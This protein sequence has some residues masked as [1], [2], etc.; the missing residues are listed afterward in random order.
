LK[1][2]ELA[3]RSGVSI[4]SIK[5]YIREGL[6]RSGDASAPNQARYSEQHLGDLSLIRALRDHA[7]LSIAAIRRVLVAVASVEG[8]PDQNLAAGVRSVEA[9]RL[10]SSQTARPNRD[11]PEYAAAFAELEQVLELHG[12]RRGEDDPEIQEVLAAML[13]V[14][15]IW[16]Y[17]PTPELWDAYLKLGQQA[18]AFE[19]PDEWDPERFPSETMRYAIVGTYLFEPVI[20]AFRRL[21]LS[22]RSTELL[23]KRQ[24]AD[25]QDALASDPLPWIKSGSE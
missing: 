24:A 13:A 21:A 9:E 14:R 16:P 8:E 11:D 10:A 25:P 18:A 15:H 6:L 1:I 2:S 7:G 23:E 4:S 5:Y 22:E 12:W 20:L 3:R 17:P 19:I